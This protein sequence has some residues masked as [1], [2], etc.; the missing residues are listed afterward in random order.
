[1]FIDQHRAHIRILYENY[2]KQFTEHKGHSQKVLFPEVIHLTKTE[3]SILE[4]IL[5]E[6]HDIGFQIDN[7]GGDSFAINGVPIGLEGLNTINLVQEIIATASEKNIS[8]KEEINISIA[9]K[10]AY[11]AAIPVGQVLGNK[12]ME[13]LVNDLFACDTV[14]YTPN[15]KT[16][17]AILKQ[18]DIDHLF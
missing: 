3:H 14:N 13:S 4:K 17:I 8:I 5:P 10:L 7:I 12:E 18:Q 6:M 9:T 11:N 1:M 16:I 15:G 2:L